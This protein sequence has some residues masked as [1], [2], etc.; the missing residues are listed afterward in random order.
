MLANVN[1]W[2]KMTGPPSIHLTLKSTMG[3]LV[4]IAG[5]IF[6]GSLFWRPIAILFSPLGIPLVLTQLRI[7]KTIRMQQS[8]QSLANSLLRLHIK[9]QGPPLQISLPVT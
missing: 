6:F 3:V 4:L 9:R 5:V 7:K 2:P 8:A 1:R